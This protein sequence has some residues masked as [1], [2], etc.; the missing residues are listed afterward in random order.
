M[1]LIF[2]ESDIEDAIPLLPEGLES[3]SVKF[4]GGRVTMVFN[5]WDE[6]LVEEFGAVLTRK[7]VSFDKE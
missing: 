3:K 5:P 2:E 7:H 1:N 4:E 6:S